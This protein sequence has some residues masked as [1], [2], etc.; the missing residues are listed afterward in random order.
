MKDTCIKIYI[1]YLTCKYSTIQSDTT[2]YYVF[3]LLH[4]DVNSV[5]YVKGVQVNAFIRKISK[6]ISPEIFFFFLSKTIKSQSY[7]KTKKTNITN[8]KNNTLSLVIHH[9]QLLVKSLLALFF[10]TGSTYNEKDGITNLIE[11]HSLFLS[12][13]STRSNRILP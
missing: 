10:H 11:T 13:Q 9:H 6:K 2:W 4:D 5:Q 12:L 1:I 7:K 3:Y 8:N